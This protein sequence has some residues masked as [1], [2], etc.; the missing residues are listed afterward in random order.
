M[1]KTDYYELLGVSKNASD[2]ELK[3]AYR[4]L[5][6]K[7]HPDRNKDDK[8]AEHKFKEINEAYEVLK[9]KQKRAAYD[10]MG[11]AA[12]SQGGG[13]PGGHYGAHGEAGFGFGGGGFSD[14]FDEVFSE[15]MG[16]GARGR[17]GAQSSKVSGSDLRY[18]L[19]IDLKDAF[20]G[21]D[22][23]ITLTRLVACGTCEG[24]GAADPKSVKTC[25]TCG[26]RG[27]MRAQQ[28]F[29]T[30]ERTC[31]TC[32]GAGEF[33]EKPC[34]DCSGMGR[35]RETKTLNVKIPAGIENGSRIRL[36]GEGEAGARGGPSGDLYVFVTVKEHELFKREA[37]NIHCDVP[38]SMI[39]ATLGGS[40]EVP[41]IDGSKAK[42]SLPEGTQSGKILRLKNKGMPVMRRSERGDMYI[43]VFVETPVS[44][45]KKQKELLK[46]FEGLN[47]SKSSPK[48]SS[49]FEQ[50]KK[51][52][53]L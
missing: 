51:F 45:T 9:D 16:G 24:S 52:W 5:A 38:V 30:I 14:I 53:V 4:K 50:I 19:S 37:H 44:L 15:F 29:F 13:H 41:T 31:S 32:H 42:V 40:I 47:S 27:K 7:Y 17:G 12:F 22:K 1:A 26:G 34:S 43:H 8:T 18:D 33:I 35:K 49:F 11:H 21:V 36:S 3:K 46:E 23:T 6:M 39:T 20:S 28:G 10:A 48:S 25:K 2:E